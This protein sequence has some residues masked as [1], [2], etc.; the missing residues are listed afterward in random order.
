MDADAVTEP[1]AERLDVDV[2]EGDAVCNANITG[3]EGAS[4][5][6]HTLVARPPVTPRYAMPFT[7]T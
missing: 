3:Q 5:S 4:S 1:E 7:R 6:L 2:S